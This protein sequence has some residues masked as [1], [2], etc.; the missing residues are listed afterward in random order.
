MYNFDN[1]A[2]RKNTYSYKWDVSED[3]LPMWVADMDFC[4][5]TPI[6]DAIKDRLDI[7][8]FGY[9]DVPREFYTAY[10]KFFCDMHGID[11]K[12]EWMVFSTGVVPSISSI[13][14]KLTQEG[15]NVCI[16]SPVYNIFYN[17]IINNNRNVLSSDLVY[18]NGEYDIDFSDLEKKL[19][20]K[21]TSLLIFCN[22]HNPTGNIWSKEELERV[23]VMCNKYDVYLISDEIHCDIITPGKKYTP[24]FSVDADTSR[25][26]MLASASK[27]YNLAGLQASVAIVQ[28]PDLKFKVWR[29]INTDECGENNFFAA[30]SHIAALNDSRDWLSEMNEYVYKNKLY[31]YQFVEK[32]MPDLSVVKS[33]ALYLV[34][35]DISKISN[36]SKKFCDDLYESEKLYLSNGSQFGKNSTSFVRVNLATSLANVKDGLN[37]LYRYYKELK[38]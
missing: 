23:V 34:W 37:R 35:V 27:C 9:S 10:R 1:I 3:A 12:E 26:I 4:V 7:R 18:K 15:D 36:D 20:D 29:G 28:N 32:N 22:P 33:D 31:F 19:S 8:A 30:A 11:L 25:V 16:M 24:I 2:N 5:A 13:V 21:K 14:R 6:V 17:S 38:K